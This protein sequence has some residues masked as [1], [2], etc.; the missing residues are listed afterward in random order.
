V[1]GTVEE[2]DLTN[3]NS[4]NNSVGNNEDNSVGKTVATG[5]L[6]SLVKVGADENGTFSLDS[7][8]ITALTSQ[9]LTSHGTALSYS[10]SG[11]TLTAKAGSIV[12]FT[13]KL[14][15]NGDYTFTLAD[16]LDH[17]NNAP[18]NTENLLNINLSSVV[19]FTDY[20]SDSI[21]LSG[22]FSITVQDDIPVQTTASVSG[23]VQ[24]DALTLLN[25][26]GQSV[27]NAEGG[28]TTVAAGSLATLVKV[29][30]D[31]PGTFSLAS[32]PSSLPS[33]TSK[34][35]TVL[36]SVSGNTLT[37][38][39][40]SGN[41]VGLDAGDRKV[42]TL[43]VQSNGNYTFT[44]LDQLDHS[45]SQ[46]N[47]D[48]QTL[49][50][51]L[52]SAVNFTD[53][54]GDTITL[55][56]GFSIYVEDDIPVTTSNSLVKADEDDIP[57]L[58][59][60]DTTS[61]GDD[62]S[63][64]L[65]G[66]LQFKV[67]ADEPASVGF[68][69]L[70]GAAVLDTSSVAVK[71]AGVA[72]HYY[73]DS[74]SGT[75]YAS[76]L[77]G[78]LTD[79][80]STAAFKV[81]VT[82][83]ATGAYTFTM[84]GQIDHPGHDD[85]G[86]AGTQTAYEDNINI[87][88]TYT[89]TDKDGDYATGTLAVSIDDDMPI[90]VPAPTNLIANGD[91]SQGTFSSQPWG[92]I[93]TPGNLTGWT[94]TGSPVDP[95]G[96]VQAERV[97]DGYLNMHTSTHGN[98][99]DMG[100]SPGNIQISQQLSGLT[101]GQTYA[102]EFEAGAPFPST[103]KLEVL[104]GNTVIGTI[105]PAGPMTSYSY[106]VTASGLAANDQITFREV[107]LGHA[108]I[109]GLADEGYHGT[110]LANVAIVSTAIVDEDGLTGLSTGNN[111]SQIGDAVVPNTDGDNNEAT[112]TGNLNIKWGAD[113]VDQADTTSA[114]FGR[115]VQDHPDAAA[116]RSVT[117]T[118]ANVSFAGASSLTSKGE[119][120][121]FQL[122]A[123]KT[124]LTAIAGGRTVFEVSLSDDG[125][126]SYRFVLLDQLDHAPNGNENDIALTF[127]YTATDSDGDAVSSKFIVS[128]DDDVPVQNRSGSVSGSVQE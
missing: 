24:E 35:E 56:G 51:N 70:N 18:Q 22:G 84:L 71:A 54:D 7:T 126:G 68:A 10:I 117:F 127:N 19:R 95:A 66:T 76:K 105:D 63:A 58:G 120:I 15:S 87:N 82:D 124:L 88:L 60:N 46:V 108:A 30:A 62:V 113:S 99:I 12:V 110:Y 81:Q 96:T 64:N 49:T 3:A 50:L 29:G 31:E 100:A 98:M 1:S 102:I 6:T 53:A 34:G 45:N 112:A 28:Q 89:V 37:A 72:L 41:S 74:A 38:Y 67:G 86:V 107:G 93:A 83:T 125:T 4:N 48:S 52:S 69:S 20:D 101:A 90:L 2:D 40:E 14:E 121:T 78:N 16:Q 42:F 91:F 118:D 85:P 104:W 43:T 57:G 79:A 36:Y 55:S 111:D 103:A 11:D 116:D 8:G 27:G 77:T 106:V 5:S 61:P 75:L 32:A 13:L 25:S 122:N 114:P 128:V 59:N 23:S 39:V 115:L 17:S 123:D 73:W 47:N 94:V 109:P 26:N 80:I 21:T 97:V 33:V 92:G 9:G 65:T 44:L 119:A